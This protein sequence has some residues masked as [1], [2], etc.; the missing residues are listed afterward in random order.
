[1][2]EQNVSLASSVASLQST[3]VSLESKMSEVSSTSALIL[4]AVNSLVSGGGDEAQRAISPARKRRIG[5]VD[6]SDEPATAASF[7]TGSAKPEQLTISVPSATAWSQ[8]RAPSPLVQLKGATLLYD[9]YTVWYGGKF[10][11][12]SYGVRWS[13]PN[14]QEKSRVLEVMNYT[15]KVLDEPQRSTLLGTVPALSTPEYTAW[16]SAF[17]IACADLVKQ[18]ASA[19]QALDERKFNKATVNALNNRLCDLKKGPKK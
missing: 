1:V 4:Q 11:A 2:K 3:V 5:A 13:A 6:Q 14:K 15:D 17:P 16:N 19:I 9:L 8:F 7:P 10:T 18:V 12:T